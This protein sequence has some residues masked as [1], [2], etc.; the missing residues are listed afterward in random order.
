MPHR[1][2]FTGCKGAS[3]WK[4]AESPSCRSPSMQNRATSAVRGGPSIFH[5]AGRAACGGASMQHR[6][7]CT[8]RQG[9][10]MRHRAAT[11][12]CR[13]RSMQNSPPHL[14][15][16]C[17]SLRAIHL[18]RTNPSRERNMVCGD[19]NQIWRT[20]QRGFALPR[21]MCLHGA[22]VHNRLRGWNRVGGG[23]HHHH[24]EAPCA[25]SRSSRKIW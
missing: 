22:R 15:A 13:C 7:V 18:I 16:G 2:G 9:R 3:I 1:A 19:H 20:G 14:P 25:P 21:R 5:R 10:W 6:A 17:L 23:L 4:R 8:A 12:G 24:H 11:T